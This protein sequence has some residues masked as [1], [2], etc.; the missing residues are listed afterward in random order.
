[1]EVS[2]RAVG[3]CGQRFEDAVHFLCDAGERELELLARAH[4]SYA[5][6]ANVLQRRRYV[7]LL[8][9]CNTRDVITRR[10]L[11]WSD[12]MECTYPCSVG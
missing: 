4:H 1:M 7:D 12:A 5:L 8:G 9:A 3:R 6:I 11:D 10:S 2:R